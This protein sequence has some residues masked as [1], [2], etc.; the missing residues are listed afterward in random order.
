M[1][2]LLGALAAIALCSTIAAAEVPDEANCTVSPADALNGL[3]FSPLNPTPAPASINTITV[4]NSANVPINNATVVVSVGAN[5]TLCGAT[6]LTGVTNA[7]GQVVLT[8]GG[9]GCAHNVANYGLVS[10]NGVT[11][12]RYSNCKSPDYDG[13]SGNLAVGLAD[14]TQFSSEFLDNAPNEC[15][16]YDNNANTGLE[17]VIIFGTPFTSAASCAP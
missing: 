3:V 4:R 8:L 11:I 6:V 1:K 12:R 14:L 13:A 16:D 5:T 2:K 15:H 10:A 7:S 9:G 17:D